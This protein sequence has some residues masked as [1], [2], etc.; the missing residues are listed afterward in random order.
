M[1]SDDHK[2]VIKLLDNNSGMM[3]ERERIGVLSL[4]NILETV[5]V[6]WSFVNMKGL[7]KYSLRSNKKGFLMILDDDAFYDSFHW[8]HA[9]T[10]KKCA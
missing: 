6:I 9:K 1:W 7:R 10:E 4:C 5:F 3:W 8:D 2:K